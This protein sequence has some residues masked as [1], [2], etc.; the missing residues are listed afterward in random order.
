[1]VDRCMRGNPLHILH[2]IFLHFQAQQLL[3]GSSFGNHHHNL[4]CRVSKRK[5]QTIR[6]LLY[7]KQLKIIPLYTKN[8]TLYF[9]I[10]SNF[11]IDP[12]SYLGMAVDCIPDL[13]ILLHH[14]LFV[15]CRQH[16]L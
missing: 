4:D 14:I 3:F 7:C 13:P 5:M 9:A 6:N 11:N 8:P 16:Q 1:M 12:N 2:R 10:F 15:E